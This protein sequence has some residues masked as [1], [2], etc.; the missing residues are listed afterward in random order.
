MFEYKADVDGE[1]VVFR[2]KPVEELPMGIALLEDYN[3]DEERQSRDMLKWALDAEQYEL[4]K[5]VS[6]SVG[7]KM[8]EAWQKGTSG[9]GLGESVASSNSSGSTARPSN[10]TSSTEVFD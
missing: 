3:G 7:M 10:A 4:L 8:I 9:T 5:R 2:L 6:I 1:R